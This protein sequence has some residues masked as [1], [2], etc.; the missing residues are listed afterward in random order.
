[1]SERFWLVKSEPEVFSIDDL[2]RVKSTG[3]EGVRNYLARNYMRDEMKPGALVLFYHSNA[4][5]S[6]VAGLAR[7]DGE[8]VPDP[9]QFNRKSQYF[10]A[11]SKKDEPRW[12]MAQLSF[13]EKFKEVLTLDELKS[14]N[15]LA[16]MPLLQKGQRLSVQP[17]DAAQFT[18]V[19]TLARAKTKM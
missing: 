3:W 2:A 14:E 19:L 15:A 12:L 5:P 17:V 13:V 1:M 11:T 16:G 18:H 7:V 4:K 9:T 6:G 10:D 8:P